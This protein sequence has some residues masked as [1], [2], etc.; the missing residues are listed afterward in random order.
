MWGIL[1]DWRGMKV[2]E[3]KQTRGFIMA[4]IRPG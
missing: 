1:G 2:S 3:E 4:L